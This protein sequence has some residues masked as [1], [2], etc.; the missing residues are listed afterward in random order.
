[1]RGLAFLLLLCGCATMTSGAPP[2]AAPAQQQ[3]A[4]PAP[5][6]EERAFAADYEDAVARA[7]KGDLAGAY[8]VLARRGAAL[9]AQNQFGIAG[10]CWNTATWV[11][12]AQGDLPGALAENARLGQALTRAE[13]E[14]RADL[15]LHY[16]WDRAY[17]LRDQA[18]RVADPEKAGARAQAETARA[19]YGRAATATEAD[20]LAVLE[21]YFA[22]R[23]HD[24][25]AATAAARR[26][27]LTR[28]QDAQDLYIVALVLEE[29]G[30]AKTAADLRARIEKAHYMMPPLL[31]HWAETSSAR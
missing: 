9:E 31:R 25:A 16:L 23:A 1:M 4:E 8:D 20:G 17:L 24:A 5:T 28:D 7:E 3:S 11:R 18:D 13:P 6:P 10:I 2:P 21:A 26:V 14:A 15:Y 22:W 19:E 30:D 12:W 29:A 27:D